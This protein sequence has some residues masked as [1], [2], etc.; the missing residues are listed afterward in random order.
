M[1]QL[2]GKEAKKGKSSNK[3]EGKRVY[4]GI[5]CIKNA[6]VYVP[7]YCLCSKIITQIVHRR[8]SSPKADA[9][10]QQNNLILTSSKSSVLTITNTNC[11][12]AK[13]YKVLGL[14]RGVAP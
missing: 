13:A 6:C 1:H 4:K 11:N 10:T 5:R 9:A 14:Q 2:W 3:H 12:R 7:L 8:I